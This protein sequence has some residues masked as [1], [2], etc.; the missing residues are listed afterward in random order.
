MNVTTNQFLEV[1]G[2]TPQQRERRGTE[3]R[4]GQQK[5]Y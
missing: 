3:G 5:L 2:R 1:I 4:G